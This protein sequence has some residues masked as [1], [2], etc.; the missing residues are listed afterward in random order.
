[1]LKPMHI[2]LTNDDGI[3]APGISALAIELSPHFMTS[4]VAPDREQSAQGTA[5]TLRQPLRVKEENNIAAVTATFAVEGTPGDSTIL[6]LE[7]LIVKDVDMLISGINKGANL[8]DDVLISG[9]VAAAL[10]GYL[11]G[12]PSL[13]ISTLVFDENSLSIASKL[14]RLFATSIQDGTLKGDFLLNVNIPDLPF[15]D[16]KGIKVARLAHKTHIDSVKKGNDGRRDYYWLVRQK[17]NLEA[18]AGSD[19]HALEQGYISITALH[20]S[21]FGRKPLPNLNII[22]E[23]LFTELKNLL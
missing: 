6:A 8:G 4:L 10:Q 20:T 11:R 3:S 14:A 13:A 2:L 22:C 1:M 9:T 15:A 16:I 18:E 7:E 5:L 23:K 17:I 19:I 21:L 12:I